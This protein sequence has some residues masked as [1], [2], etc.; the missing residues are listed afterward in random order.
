MTLD[1]A[2]KRYPFLGFAV[3]AYQPGYPLTVEVITATEET[4]TAAGQTEEDALRSLFPDATDTDP[5]EHQQKHEE[6]QNDIPI[7]TDVF[8]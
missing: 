2:R 8:A 4:F 3:Y 7:Q 1:E 6:K 5:Q